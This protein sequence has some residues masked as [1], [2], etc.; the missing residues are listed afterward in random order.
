MLWDARVA[1][2]RYGGCPA[3]TQ[4]AKVSDAHTFFPPS[5]RKRRKDSVVMVRSSGSR[6]ACMRS[7]SEMKIALSGSVGTVWWQVNAGLGAIP[8]WL[9]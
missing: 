4:V 8:H 3:H 6:H 7:Q 5:H 9:G 2:G 1:T